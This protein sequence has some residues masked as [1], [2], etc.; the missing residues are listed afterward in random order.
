DGELPPSTSAC[1]SEIVVVTTPTTLSTTLSGGIEEGAEIEVE[2]GTPV[3][4]QA[5]LSGANASTAEGSVEYQVF[6][7]SEC[8]QLVAQLGKGAM[9]GGTAA[10]SEEE[11]L[12]PGTYYWQARYSGDGLN[13]ASESSCGS[14]KEKVTAPVTTK[15]TA[16]EE[17]EGT[18]IEVSAG[19]PVTDTA[20]LHGPHATTATGTV[21]YL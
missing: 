19:T 10:P 3:S 6:A 12:P 11:V 21:K 1:G 20:T 2:E 17:L 16:E 7:D 8:T 18:E 14:E 9:S 5:V 15:L 13:H 4:D